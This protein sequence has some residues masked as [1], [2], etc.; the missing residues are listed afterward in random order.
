MTVAMDETKAHA[1]LSPVLIISGLAQRHSL[2]APWLTGL[3]LWGEHLLQVHV[4]P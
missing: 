1:G 2:T 3:G 4:F